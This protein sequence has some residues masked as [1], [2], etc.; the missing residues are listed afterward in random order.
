MAGDAMGV[1]IVGASATAGAS[2][3]VLVVEASVGAGAFFSCSVWGGG[4]ESTKSISLFLRAEPIAKDPM[5][6]SF[7]CGHSFFVIACCFSNSSWR[8]A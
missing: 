7:E 3:G 8:I 4:N 1:S 5:V 2:L 6:K